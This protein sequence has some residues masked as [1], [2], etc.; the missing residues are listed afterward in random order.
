MYLFEFT[1]ANRKVLKQY[2]H[3]SIVGIYI[4]SLFG[5]SSAFQYAY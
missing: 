2:I 5:T 1:L 3:N 4:K